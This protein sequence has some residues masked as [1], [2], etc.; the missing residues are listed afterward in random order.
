MSA[1]VTVCVAVQFNDA[2]GANEEPLAGVQV[3]PVTLGSLT[4]TDDSVGAGVGDTGV[5]GEE[6]DD[7]EEEAAPHAAANTAIRN[8]RAARPY[9]R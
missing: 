5:L 2:P 8:A 7:D 9:A 3:S 6:D 1:C 4:V